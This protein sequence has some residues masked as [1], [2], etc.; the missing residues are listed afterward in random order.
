LQKWGVFKDEEEEI[1]KAEKESKG[2]ISEE[3]NLFFIQTKE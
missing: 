2:T 3:D 1:K